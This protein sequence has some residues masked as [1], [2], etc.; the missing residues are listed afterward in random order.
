MYFS[1]MSLLIH[2]EKILT[3]SL[4]SFFSS[5]VSSFSSSL[6]S[7]SSFFT[8]SVPSLL[9]SSFPSSFFSSSFP[10]S[11]V[12]SSFPSSFFSYSSSVSPSA[13]FASSS[14]AS[15]CSSSSTSGFASG[16]ICMLNFNIRSIRD[17]KSAESWVAKK[18][19][20]RL[21]QK[22]DSNLL[23]ISSNTFYN[24][25]RF[26]RFSNIDCFC[27]FVNDVYCLARMLLGD[28]RNWPKDVVVI[29][30]H[31]CVCYRVNCCL[32]LVLPTNPKSNG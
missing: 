2:D 10:S 28:H 20:K 18:T 1:L 27:N 13:S 24:T 21:R 14:S 9:S 8:S 29:L 32:I 30:P 19:T 26:N 22:F 31:S 6:L 11:F 16:S 5:T 3:S 7:P 12:S 23:L 15:S 4:C 25:L 17:A